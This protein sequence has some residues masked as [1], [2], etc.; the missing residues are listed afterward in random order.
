MVPNKADG[1]T[2][3]GLGAASAGAAHRVLS[4]GSDDGRLALLLG[5]KS[6]WSRV[7]GKITPLLSYLSHSAVCRYITR[8]PLLRFGTP[9][10]A[11]SSSRLIESVEMKTSSISVGRPGWLASNVGHLRGFHIGCPERFEFFQ[12]RVVTSYG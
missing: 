12:V 11:E 7:V 3:T 4:S 10:L 5:T 1:G 8:G 9:I 2:L 6:S